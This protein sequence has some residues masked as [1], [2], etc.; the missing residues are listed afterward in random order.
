MAGAEQSKRTEYVVIET[1]FGES[2]LT[3]IVAQPSPAAD[4]LAAAW[5]LVCVGTSITGRW[6]TSGEEAAATVEACRELS[7]RERP[8]QRS[9]VVFNPAYV[10]YVTWPEE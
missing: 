7:R 6:L 8:W 2:F 5:R 9:S 1:S 4:V 3:E 10:R